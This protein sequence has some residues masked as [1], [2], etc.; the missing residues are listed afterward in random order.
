MKNKFIIFLKPNTFINN[1]GNIINK[2]IYKKKISIKDIFIICDDINLYFGNLK[3]NKQGGHGGHNGLK[4]IQSILKTYYY[5]RLRFGIGKKFKKGEQSN[6]VLDNFNNYE[7][8]K[9]ENII[10]LIKKMI[11]NFIFYGIDHT[12]NLFNKKNY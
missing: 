8:E 2:W 1:S 5:S 11:L 9:I 12:M 6:Y 10:P 7:I 4:N 3:I